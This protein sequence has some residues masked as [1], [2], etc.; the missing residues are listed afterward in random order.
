LRGRW[1]LDEREELIRQGKAEF[2]SWEEA[3]RK[4]DEAC[5]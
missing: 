2:I 5:P 4:I 1:I 3:K